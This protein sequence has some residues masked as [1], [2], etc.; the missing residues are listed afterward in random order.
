M[1]KETQYS[2]AKIYGTLWKMTQKNCLTRLQ[3]LWSSF[4]KP[5]SASPKR[6]WEENVPLV[7]EYLDEAIAVVGKSIQIIVQSFSMLELRRKW[8]MI[9]LKTNVLQVRENTR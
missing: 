5:S 6:L 3:R 8:G 2:K 4:L 9:S 7:E 1:K